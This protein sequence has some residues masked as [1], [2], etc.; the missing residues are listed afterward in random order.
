VELVEGIGEDV[1]THLEAGGHH[2]VARFPA[3]RRVRRGD[4]V[5]IAAPPHRWYLF[6]ATTGLTVRHAA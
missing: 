3:E 1:F 2:L 4:R 6:N 5:T